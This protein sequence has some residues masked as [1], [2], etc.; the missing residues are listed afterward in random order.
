LLIGAFH[1]SSKILFRE[2]ILCGL[3]LY[4][5]WV[6]K[7]QEHRLSSH[8]FVFCIFVP[9]HSAAQVRKREAKLNEPGVELNE[10]G[11]DV[12]FKEP[13][14]QVHYG[15]EEGDGLISKIG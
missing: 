3:S 13:Q 2:I 11:S 9:V 10:P 12:D 5:K 8:P 15:V 1:Q 7:E 6:V 14:I 4:S